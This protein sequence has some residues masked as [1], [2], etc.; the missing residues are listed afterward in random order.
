[1]L[2]EETEPLSKCLGFAQGH[3]VQGS[4]VKMKDEPRAMASCNAEQEL[5]TWF[6]LLHTASKSWIQG[7][8]HIFLGFVSTPAR[9]TTI[10]NAY[11]MT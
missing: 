9:P 11:Q 2:S 3:G 8:K 6:L 10:N 7:R 4:R 1:M 5:K